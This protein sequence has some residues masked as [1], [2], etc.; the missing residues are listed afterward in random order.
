MGDKV[1]G[2]I[3]CSLVRMRSLPL[4]PVPPAGGAASASL[5]LVRRSLSFTARSVS[6]LTLIRG[7]GY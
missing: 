3:A 4:P 2:R 6:D 7:E 1:V 5:T